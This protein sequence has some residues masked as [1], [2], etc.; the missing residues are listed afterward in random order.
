LL[1][2]KRSPKINKFPFRRFL[3]ACHLL[4]NLSIDMSLFISIDVTLIMNKREKCYN[5]ALYKWKK[6]KQQPTTWIH[7][8]IFSFF[9]HFWKWKS[10]SIF[11]CAKMPYKLLKLPIKHHSVIVCEFT[12]CV[13][14]ILTLTWTCFI[15]H[16]ISIFLTI[17]LKSSMPYLW[18]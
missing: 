12:K 15:L 2:S 11:F 18:W 16:L 1:G 9:Y 6:P 17:I 14:V 4:V 13:N 7:L 8:I 3:F 5:Q 10:T